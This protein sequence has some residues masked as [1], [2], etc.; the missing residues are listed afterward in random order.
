[1]SLNIKHLAMALML[2]AID[3]R[4]FCLAAMNK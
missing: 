2:W 3:K 4:F 1:M